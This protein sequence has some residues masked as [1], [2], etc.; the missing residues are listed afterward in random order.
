[1]KIRK[2]IIICFALSTS[3]LSAQDVIKSSI[4]DELNSPKLMQGKVR[5]MQDESIKNIVA[6][7][8]PNDTI[9]IDWG[10]VNHVKVNGFKIQVFSGNN[11]RQSKD[12]AQSKAGMVRSAYPN[13]EVTVS[14]NPPFWRVR[15]G[16]FLTRSD[17]EEVLSEMKKTFPSFG[18]E[19]YIIENVPVKRI[20]E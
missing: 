16:N 1:M 17:A 5:V 15:V 20:V 4:I 9:A 13:Q 19:M 11:Q 14:Y 18:R 7:Y 10:T 2:E 6:V 8:N 12:E 3:Y